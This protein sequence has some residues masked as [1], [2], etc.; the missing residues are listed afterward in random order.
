MQ[1]CGPGRP[2]VVPPPTTS[3]RGRTTQFSTS[4]PWYPP[5]LD[6]EMVPGDCPAH[7]SFVA[8]TVFPESEILVRVHSAA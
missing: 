4:N 5:K 3:V 1:C 2:T 8:T 6:A 7:T